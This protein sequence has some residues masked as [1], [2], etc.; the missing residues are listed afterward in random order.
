MDFL[1]SVSV[2]FEILC[3]IPSYHFRMKK[4][5]RPEEV[6]STIPLHL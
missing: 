3:L 4:K 5:N 2:E 6:I 1:T